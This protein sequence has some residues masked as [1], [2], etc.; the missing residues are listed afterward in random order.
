M[1]DRSD[2]GFAFGEGLMAGEADGH[3]DVEVLRS[4]RVAIIGAGM[5]GIGMAAKLRLAGIESF[6]IYEK[7]DDVGGTWHANTYPG[8][9]CDVPSRYYSYTFAPNPNWSHVYSPGRE[10]WAYLDRVARDFELYDRIAL[11]TDVAE[12]NWADGRWLLRTSNGEEVEYDFIVTA[13]GG[14]VHTVKPNIPGLDSFGARCSTR[15][16]GITR[17]RW[18]ADE[19]RS[20]GPGRPECSSRVRSLPSPGTSISSSEHRSGSSRCPTAGTRA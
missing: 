7:S 8:L 3:R 14:L 2:T 18:R 13:A 6:R 15:R 1:A 12:A 4:P 9:T 20:S 17:C 19:S 10:I 16:S 5:S 11:R